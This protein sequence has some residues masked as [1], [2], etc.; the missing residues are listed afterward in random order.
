MNE[1]EKIKKALLKKALGYSADEVVCEY[2]LDDD[3]Q[4]KLCKKKV[5]RKHFAP[6]I[7]A[8][9]LLLE[10]HSDEDFDPSKMS[11]QE[12]LNERERLLN[13]LKEDK[14]KNAN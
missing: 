11:D 10:Q 4:E 8:V 5:T 1:E 14:D 2:V 12:L 13:L 3:G 6:D 7:S 9:K